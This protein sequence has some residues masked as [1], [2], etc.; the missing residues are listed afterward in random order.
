[1]EDP[2]SSTSAAQAL[3]G[4][5]APGKVAEREASGSSVIALAA[6]VVLL[7]LSR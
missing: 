3:M 2:A 5:V 6:M 1:M 4:A 7:V